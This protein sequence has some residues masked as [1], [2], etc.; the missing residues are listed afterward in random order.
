MFYNS[1]PEA[2]GSCLLTLP[3]EAKKYAERHKNDLD[4]WSEANTKPGL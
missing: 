1:G 4:R 3:R 2:Q